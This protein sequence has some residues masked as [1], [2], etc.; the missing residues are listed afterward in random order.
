MV[1]SSPDLSPK[2]QPS[3][4]PSRPSFLPPKPPTPSKPPKNPALSGELPVPISPTP[5]QPTPVDLN[6]IEQQRKQEL[7]A[8]RAV[9]QS[10]KGK[11]NPGPSL[12]ASNSSTFGRD[13]EALKATEEALS[14]RRL[15]A[16]DPPEVFRP[17]LARS[18]SNFSDRLPIPSSPSVQALP[19]P[20]AQSSGRQ[21]SSTTD[22]MQIDMFI[23]D[24]I[25]RNEDLP[26]NIQR[27]AEE[28]PRDAMEVEQALQSTEKEEYTAF[29][30]LAFSRNSGIQDSRLD[31]GHH[32]GNGSVTPGTSGP[33]TLVQHRPSENGNSSS[34][35]TPPVPGSPTSVS[36]PPISFQSR[37]NATAPTSLK[38]IGKRPVAA[39]FVDYT[40]GDQPRSRFDPAYNEAAP[41][42]H[43]RRKHFG[44]VVSHR[45]VIDVSDGE[46]GTDEEDDHI[47]EPRPLSDL[48]GS[49]IQT[50]AESHREGS[51]PVDDDK[52][53]LLE[54]KQKEI[55][56]MRE[57]IR[58]M[59]EKK[60]RTALAESTSSGEGEA[61]RSVSEATTDSSTSVLRPPSTNSIHPP[62]QR[63]SGVSAPPAP[64]FTVKTED[65]SPD[66]MTGVESH[67]KRDSRSTAA[68]SSST[69][70]MSNFPSSSCASQLWYLSW[71]LT[72]H[73][74]RHHRPHSF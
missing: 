69:V 74:S 56:R 42:H 27:E 65:L 46:A 54:E 13:E 24:A 38:R 73:L 33:S 37:V 53:K 29:S 63:I 39:D 7:M 25:T 43:K 44:P 26:K 19:P 22:D 36:S 35:A 45:L 8:R 71:T 9:L 57:L 51:A 67:G 14:I 70:T 58:S 18:V 11:S 6:D 59:E 21:E 32:L 30:G 68:D 31:M 47:P 20:Q 40:P 5:V 48:N 12:F 4:L 23:A 2:N 3:S 34:F 1:V 16:A 64:S 41:P 10:L 52:L 61:T 49:V 72:I 66:F 15:L 55:L 62:H 28:S 60:R 50:P 17:D